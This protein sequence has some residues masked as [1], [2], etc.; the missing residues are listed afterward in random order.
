MADGVVLFDGVCNLCNASVLFVIDRDPDSRFRFAAL[1]SDE[2]QVLLREIDADRDHDRPLDLS[3][4]LL[5]E[6]P[7]VYDRSGAALRIAR[8][9][10]GAWP[11][12]SV[13]LL[14]PRP[15]RDAVYNWIAR[16][17]YRW[18]GRQDACRIPTPELRARFLDARD[19]ATGQ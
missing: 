1:Q 7:H 3:S 11:V 14:V 12:L 4:V 9:L 10:S 17:R 18:F 16:N 2:A 13:F 8:K 19:S 6:G 15:I 5:I